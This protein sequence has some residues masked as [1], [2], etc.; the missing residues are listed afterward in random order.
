M[1]LYFGRYP[2]SLN[3][4]T[5]RKLLLK[6]SDTLCRLSSFLK[7]FEKP[8]MYLTAKLTRYFSQYIL[9]K[10]T[11]MSLTNSPN[12][13]TMMIISF[14]TTVSSEGLAASRDDSQHTFVIGDKCLA[15]WPGSNLPSPVTPL[16]LMMD[17][18]QHHTIIVTIK[19]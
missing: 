3:M 15:Y 9:I 11:K 2:S 14:L 10:N 18:A 19:V 12:A 16:Q 1:I 7:G 6:I 8:V 17:N 5:Q 13:T 4:G